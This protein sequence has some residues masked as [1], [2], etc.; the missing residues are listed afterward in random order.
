M[1]YYSCYLA[2]PF[3]ITMKEYNPGMHYEKAERWI[4]HGS[5]YSHLDKDISFARLYIKD[6]FPNLGKILFLQNDG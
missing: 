4:V 3:R 1:Y 5:H 6:Y 2:W